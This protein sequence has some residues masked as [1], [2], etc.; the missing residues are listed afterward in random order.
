MLDN[1]LIHPR[2]RLQ[3]E[4]FLAHPTHGLILTGPD[5]SGKQTLAIAVAALILN[6]NSAE[7]LNLYPYY[8]V[9]DPV[10]ATITIEEIRTLQKLLTLRTPKVAGQTLR[11]ILCVIDAG[12]MRIEAQNAFL[13]SLEEPPADTLIIFTAE[14]NNSLLPT[15][16][17]R[18][19]QIEV[20]PVSETTAQAFYKQ[21]GISTSLITKNYALSQ[22]QVGLLHS[23]LTDTEHPLKNSVETAKLLL[24]KIAAERLELVDELSKD[25]VAISLLLNSFARITHAAL[26]AAGKTNNQSNI[27]RWKQCSALIQKT[28]EAMTHNANT[29]L[30]LDKLLLNL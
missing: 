25:K 12:R 30:L 7:A 8:S 1:L 28:N 11:R 18:L 9:T 6:K 24:S 4:T 14:A 26:F 16:F 17:S 2:T 19:Q 20:L 15:I 27:T 10:E 23:L 21:Q 13:K 5:G 3:L 22:G 29:K